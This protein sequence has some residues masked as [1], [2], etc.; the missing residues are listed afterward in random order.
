MVVR[1][2]FL[3]PPGVG[4][5]APIAAM[6]GDTAVEGGPCALVSEIQVTAEIRAF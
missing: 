4:S 3:K 5:I 6:T 1:Y 2:L